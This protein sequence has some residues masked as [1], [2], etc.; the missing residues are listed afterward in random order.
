MIN[1]TAK[2]FEQKRWLP[3]FGLLLTLTALGGCAVSANVKQIDQLDTVSGKPTIVVM[4]PDIR[5]YLLTAG[6]VS[7]PNVEWTEA[8]QANFST[9][10]RDY[11]TANG[12]NI[13]EIDRANMGEQDL[14]YES[15]HAVVGRTILIHHFGAFKLPSKGERFDWSL[16]PEV[17]TIGKN[18]DA[19]YALFVTYRDYQASGGRV[20]FSVLAAVAGVGVSTGSESGF[21]SLV[22][23]KSGDIVWFNVVG[24][25]SGELRDVNGAAAAVKTL[26]KDLPGVSAAD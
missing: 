14:E 25:G 5:Y 12:S 3:M 22:D 15:L 1:K 6:G 13:R 21:A 7:E 20:A 2:Q 4:P 16:G 8:A 17:A 11:A 24:A 9:A 10:L 26:F 23:L 18:H 19:D